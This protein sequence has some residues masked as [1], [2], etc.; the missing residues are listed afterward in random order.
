MSWSA[1]RD[2]ITLPTSV[3]AAT[4]RS[5]VTL[6]PC[7]ASQA[8]TSA[9]GSGPCPRPKRLCIHDQDDDLFRRHQ[10]GKCLGRCARAFAAGVPAQHDRIAGLRAN[11]D[12]AGRPASRD[13]TKSPASPGDRRC[14]RFT[15]RLG[16]AENKQVGIASL[17]DQ[18]VFVV[19][20]GETPFARQ[21]RALDGLVKVAAAVSCSAFAEAS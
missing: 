9:P 16:L 3:S 10:E 15:V 20:L 1:A 21:V 13:R 19:T 2:R 17:N 18:L 12:D 6:T 11:T 7:R 5:T 4:S 8:A 14:Q